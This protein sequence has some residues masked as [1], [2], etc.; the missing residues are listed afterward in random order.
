MLSNVNQIPELPILAQSLVHSLNARF[1]IKKLRFQVHIIT[2]QI[3]KYF[4]ITSVWTR[5]LNFIELTKLQN[6]LF[7]HK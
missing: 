7:G 6:G 2:L 4:Q 1:R 5:P 3:L